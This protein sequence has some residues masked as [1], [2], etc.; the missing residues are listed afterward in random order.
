MLASN[1]S[2][3][4]GSPPEFLAQIN[5]SYTVAFLQAI[6]VL[7]ANFDIVVIVA[8]DYRDNHVKMLIL[9]TY[10]PTY[11]GTHLTRNLSDQ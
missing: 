1:L 7:L 3:C 8:F 6:V 10:V 2:V 4:G 9:F 5:C 11:I